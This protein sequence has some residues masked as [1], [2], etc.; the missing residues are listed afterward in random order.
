MPALACAAALPPPHPAAA[1]FFPA[2]TLD[3]PGDIVRVGDVDVAR[4]GTGAV[5]YVKRE[6]GTEHVFVSRLVNGACRPPVTTR[7]RLESPRPPSRGIRRRA[8]AVA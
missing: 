6:G 3:G 8:A 2:E 7:R 1:D 5:V 4:D